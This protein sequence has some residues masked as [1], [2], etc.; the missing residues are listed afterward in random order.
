VAAGNATNPPQQIPLLSRLVLGA[1]SALSWPAI[2]IQEHHA[3]V[4]R[5]TYEAG[6]ERRLQMQLQLFFNTPLDALLAGNRTRHEGRIWKAARSH[7]IRPH[8]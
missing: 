3:G 8:T 4:A 1:L 2:P 6:P 5:H 7:R